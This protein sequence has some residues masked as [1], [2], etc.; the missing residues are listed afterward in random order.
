M[1]LDKARELGIAL[2]E[3]EEFIQMRQARVLL[4]ADSEVTDTLAQFKD[5]QGELVAQLSSENADKL[6]VAALSREVE[7]LQTQL[8]ENPIFSGA[9]EAQNAFQL[10]MSEVNKEIGACI[11]IET[12][13]ASDGCCGSCEGCSGC[14]H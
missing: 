6:L 8:M 11:G 5:K 12:E 7:L 13:A 9:I 1:I 3:S 2:S 4:D 14:S 10:L